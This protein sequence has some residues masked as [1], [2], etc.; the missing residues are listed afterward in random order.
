MVRTIRIVI[1]GTAMVLLGAAGVVGA[2]P[3]SA[4]DTTPTDQ[5]PTLPSTYLDG[6]GWWNKIQQAPQGGQPLPSAACPASAVSSCTAGPPA[7]GL[8]VVYDYEAV[9]PG[10]VT[11]P[12]NNAPTPP[13]LPPAPSTVPA[14]TVAQ[15]HPLGPTA[16]GAVRF[17]VPDGAETELTLHIVSKQN[18][19]PGGQDLS[20][21]GIVFGCLVSTPG[22]AA[23]Q[24]G[25]YDQAPKYDCSSANQGTISGDAVT[26][27]FPSGMVQDGTLD[28]AIVGSGTQP[29]QMAL[30]KPTDS[31]VVVTNA[32]ALASDVVTADAALPSPDATFEDPA[33]ASIDTASVPLDTGLTSDVPLTADQSALPSVSVGGTRTRPQIAVNA[34]RIVNPFSPDASRADRIMAVAILLLMGTGLWWVGGLP[35]RGPRLLGSLGGGRTT[36]ADDAVAPGGIGRFVRARTGRP[37]RL[38]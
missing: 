24:N 33:A 25:R 29:F 27:T 5:V 38:F 1:V 34:G 31:S 22:W 30:D 35:M 7:D 19:T 2:L 6:Y 20:T 13:T 28:V 18:T 36:E 8:Y 10:A 32:D 17:T 3:A 23:A 4:A 21:A 14:P 16:Y 11:G 9:A 12:V 15:P 26:F 37:P